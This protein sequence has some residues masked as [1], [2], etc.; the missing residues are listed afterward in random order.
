MNIIDFDAESE[1]T[2]KHL[3]Q[4]A[5]MREQVRAALMATVMGGDPRY[6]SAS[7]PRIDAATERVLAVVAERERVLRKRIEA[8]TPPAGPAHWGYAKGISDVLAVFE[9]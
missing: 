2:R 6:E 9:S 1:R 5:D 4:R 8:L 3:K 7:L